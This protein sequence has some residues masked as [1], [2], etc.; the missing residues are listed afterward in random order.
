MCH[1]YGLCGKKTVTTAESGQCVI[2]MDC[3]VGDEKTVT[4][5][6]SGQCVI[7]MVFC[8]E[9]EDISFYAFLI[10]KNSL[11]LTAY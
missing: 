8:F 1:Y 6:E 7:I 9:I 11:T 4:T 10:N 2:I 5:A 3:V